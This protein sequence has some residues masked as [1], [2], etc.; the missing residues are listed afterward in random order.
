MKGEIIKSKYSRATRVYRR[1]ELQLQPQNQNFD[2]HLLEE[3]L[4]L[5]DVAQKQYGQLS[6]RYQELE[7][8]ATQSSEFVG[9]QA[10]VNQAR[11]A[12]NQFN[13]EQ[14]KAYQML[15]QRPDDESARAAN[16]AARRNLH[17]AQK[18]L[19]T[20]TELQNKALTR[21]IESSERGNEIVELADAV[22]ETVNEAFK[23]LSGNASKPPLAA[24]TVAALAD[25]EDKF[26]KARDHH[27]NAAFW[28]QLAIFG[29]GVASVA[30]GAF[31]YTADPSTTLFQLIG[32]GGSKL[33]L[34]VVAGWLLVHFSRS[35][36]RHN[37]QAV[38]YEDKLAGLQSADRLLPYS[39]DEG[40]KEILE[41]ILS[42]YV[43]VE[44]NAFVDTGNPADNLAA[45]KPILDEIRKTVKPPDPS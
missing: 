8:A 2:Y 37:Q 21:G 41:T 5:H 32:R 42:T 44:R 16:D 38:T 17:E 20:V 30:L 3:L 9:A 36:A 19:H 34:I 7:Q 27:R 24:G 15:S 45:V 28:S 25:S 26:K 31:A 4:E 33:G 29:I 23:V 18:K 40:R 11:T 6:Q 12:V 35:A 13:K 22:T 14:Q 43:A 39:N 10:R 1:L